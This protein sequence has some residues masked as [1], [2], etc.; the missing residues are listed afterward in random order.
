MPV[1]TSYSFLWIS[2]GSDVALG[3]SEWQ[4]SQEVVQATQCWSLETVNTKL[5]G[6]LHPV[7]GSRR[8]IAAKASNAVRS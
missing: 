8:L 6:T 4:L 7:G 2:L 1:S 3:V 5:W